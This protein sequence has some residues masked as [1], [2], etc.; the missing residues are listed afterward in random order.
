MQ[1][2]CIPA[3]FSDAAW[4]V[5]QRK[6][7]ARILDCT[8]GNRH[9]WGKN[10]MRDDVIFTDKE[11]CLKI[12]PDLLTTWCDLPSHFPRDYFHCIIFDPP[13][14]QGNVFP[15]FTHPDENN[16]ENYN[17]T[18][19][20]YGYP[21]SSKH[22]MRTELLWA[23]CDL[24]KLSPRMCFKWMNRDLTIDQVITLFTWWKPTWI[25]PFKSKS[26]HKSGETWWVKLVRRG[27]EI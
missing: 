25:Q 6:P 21:F 14:Y 10:K 8:A 1:V 24:A 17:G 2:E 13:F 27:F 7:T 12:A 5:V 18:Q 20:W 11:P 4:A 3:G 22:K 16:E 19:T 9:I 26:N 15:Y 23:Q